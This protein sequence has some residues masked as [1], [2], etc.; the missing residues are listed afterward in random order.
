MAKILSPSGETEFFEITELQKGFEKELKTGEKVAIAPGV[1]E[2]SFLREAPV[3]AEYATLFEQFKDKVL[4]PIDPYQPPVPRFNCTAVLRTMTL[5]ISPAS[6]NPNGAV[7]PGTPFWHPYIEFTTVL[8]TSL[9]SVPAP[10]CNTDFTG[11]DPGTG[12][13]NFTPL[14]FQ[15]SVN[16]TYPSPVQIIVPD[17]YTFT[18]YVFDWDWDDVSLPILTFT[19]IKIT[20]AVGGGTN[21]SS[22]PFSCYNIPNPTPPASQA[23]FEIK[24]DLYVPKYGGPFLYGITTD[25]SYTL[26]NYRF[27]N[28]YP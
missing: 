12:I 8:D 22:G 18:G 17:Y 1:R 15:N 16:K 5:E 23:I 14:P 10:Q 25:C 27:T 28:F 7:G 24:A 4:N 3:R 20:N 21:Y 9:Y 26:F 2:A 13:Y 11:I 6:V 19:D